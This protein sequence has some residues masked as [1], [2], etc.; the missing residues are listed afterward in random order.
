MRK[1]T[2]HYLL[3]ATCLFSAGTAWA[4]TAA[5]PYQQTFDSGNALDNFTILDSNGDG[6]TWKLDRASEEVTSERDFGASADDWLVT[7]SF[8]LKAGVKYTFKFEA[9]C[10]FNGNTETFDVMLGNAASTAALDTPLLTGSKV[11]TNTPSAT[12]EKEITVEADGNYYIG[13]HH[14]TQN[15]FFGNSLCID[16]ISLSEKKA[17][18]ASKPNPVSD[19]TFDYNYDTHTATLKWKAPTAYADGTPIDAQDVTYTV[20]HVGN[21]TPIVDQYPGTTVREQL[22][23]KD[24]PENKIFFGQGLA[25]YAIVAHT[26]GGDSEKALSGVRIIG[27]PDTLPYKESFADG[28]AHTFWAET[29]D[30]LGRWSPVHDINNSYTQDGDFGMY[31]YSGG[32]DNDKAQ[33]FSGL[34]DLDGATNPTL[35]FWY[36]YNGIYNDRLSLQVATDGGEF[37]TVRDI[38]L[39]EDLQGTWI[40]AVVPLS[41]YKGARF[42]QVGF[43]EESAITTSRIYIDNLRVYDQTENCLTADIVSMPANLRHDEPRTAVVKVSNYGSNDMAKGSYNVK[44]MAGGKTI[45]NAEGPA[46]TKDGETTV[47][48]SLSTDITLTAD[49]VDTYASICIDG[50]ETARTATTPVRLIQTSY[51]RPAGL[52]ANTDGG[53]AVLTWAAPD[54]PRRESKSVT[55][56][57]EDAPDFTISNW[58]DWIL[59]DF[60][61]RLVYGIEEGSFPNMSMPQAFTVLNPKAAKLDESWSTHSGDKM[62]AAFATLTEPLN[63]WIVS[64][65]LAREAQTVSFFARAYSNLYQETFDVLYSTESQNTEDFKTL[66]SYTTPKGKTQWNEYKAELPAGTKYFAIKATSDNTFALLIDDITFI[67]DSCGAQDISLTGYNVYRDGVKVNSQPVAAT[68]FTDNAPTGTHTYAVSAVYDEGESG[69]SNS[70]EASTTTSIAQPSAAATADGGKAYDLEGRRINGTPRGLFIKNGKKYMK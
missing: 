55:D 27:T 4:Q 38:T 30:G 33:G 16:N 35:S 17:V 14:N 24:L 50:N 68:T 69:L 31:S 21:A 15:E 36:Y 54:A 59:H 52:D 62:L 29:H 70:V 11:E 58:G 5:L 40:H 45:G 1:S 49:S 3:V 42:I 56:G 60:N 67:P 9:H 53:A 22:E 48:V 7:P 28:K 61:N 51:P 64:P 19:I 43:S 39:D 46:L 25:C 32:N 23:L 12:F 2:L 66:K 37:S 10:K 44:V 57:F 13:F 47:A 34:I 20:T 63:H 18:S 65:K 26:P 41:A 8:A 6:M